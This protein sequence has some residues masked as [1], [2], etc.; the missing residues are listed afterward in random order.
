VGRH[1]QWPPAPSPAPNASL[2]ASS[3][4]DASWARL[5]SPYHHWPLDSAEE[6]ECGLAGRS[7]ELCRPEMPE[8]V[9]AGSWDISARHVAKVPPRA[10]ASLVA[11]VPAGQP[12]GTAARS[13]DPVPLFRLRSVPREVAIEIESLSWYRQIVVPVESC[14]AYAH[15]VDEHA[16]LSDRGT[17]NA[18]RHKKKE[19]QNEHSTGIKSEQDVAVSCLQA[20]FIADCQRM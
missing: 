9:E 17:R 12:V 13:S 19:S 18:L 2:P 10:V 20:N 5:R 4:A 6:T 8:E 14:V 11:Q 3:A 15:E 1:V 7:L 16:G